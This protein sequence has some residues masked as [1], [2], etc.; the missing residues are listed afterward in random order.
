MKKSDLN[1]NDKNLEKELKQLRKENERL[2]LK[3]QT[4]ETENK[5]LKKELKKKVV[6]KK[7]LADEQLKLLLKLFR[8]IDSQS[9]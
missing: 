4:T 3:F 8:D 1:N 5:E 2:K 7:T 9:S 6:P